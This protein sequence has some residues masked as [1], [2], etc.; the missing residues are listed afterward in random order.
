MAEKSIIEI[1]ND[2]NKDRDKT[3]F[4]IINLVKDLGMDDPD[5]DERRKKEWTTK[6]RVKKTPTFY[7]DIF[8][9]Y[10]NIMLEAQTAKGQY[11]EGKYKDPEQ[12]EFWTKYPIKDGIEDKKKEGEHKKIYITKQ[13]GSRGISKSDLFYSKSRD[14]AHKDFMKIKE[15]EKRLAKEETEKLKNLSV[16]GRMAKHFGENAD[17]R[18]QLFSMLGSMGRELVKPIQP[19]QAAAGALLPTL[20]RGLGKGEEEWA[21]KEAAETKRIVDLASAR[22]NVNPLQYYSNAMKEA[23][24][25]VPEGTPG[26]AHGAAGKAWIGNYLR[27]IGIPS[28]VVDLGNSITEQQLLLTTAPEDQRDLIQKNINEMLIQQNT[29]LNQ[30]MGS[31]GSTDTGTID[32]TKLISGSF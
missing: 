14:K 20:S 29:L 25:M 21:A 16:W 23:A 3:D 28:Q 11:E 1:L 26:G 22:A 32:Y 17:K 27:S 31:G 7:D 8:R 4:D 10:E 30:M 12:K 19:G 18:D 6:E 9:K 2:W 24:L 15:E 5:F 13:P